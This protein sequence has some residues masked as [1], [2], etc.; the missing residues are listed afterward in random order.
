MIFELIGKFATFIQSMLST[1]V[2][3]WDMP[4]DIPT[5]LRSHPRSS[6]QERARTL[7]QDKKK[8]VHHLL[9]N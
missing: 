3:I 5:F 6:K 4:N 7:E 8:K 1:A 9:A 2:K